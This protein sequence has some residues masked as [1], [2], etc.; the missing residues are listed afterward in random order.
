MPQARSLAV[1]DKPVILKPAVEAGT[2]EAQKPRG[3]GF[4]ACRLSKG[5]FEVFPFD[6][7]EHFVKRL[8]SQLRAQLLSVESRSK[9]KWQMTQPDR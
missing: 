9:P 7:R 2:G 1:S 5:C 6:A 3:L 8:D 4:V